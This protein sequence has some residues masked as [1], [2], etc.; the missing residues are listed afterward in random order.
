MAGISD[1][2]KRRKDL[3]RKALEDQK[4]I[5]ELERDKRQAALDFVKHSNGDV[6]KASGP[7]S[8]DSR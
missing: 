7:V 6:Q 3:E 5:L 4:K 2:S 8:G 1:S